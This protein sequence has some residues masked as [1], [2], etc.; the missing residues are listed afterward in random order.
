METEKVLW[1]VNYDELKWFVGRAKYVKATAVAIRTDNDLLKA[2]PA[3]KDEGIKVYGW[4]WPSAKRDAAMKEAAKVADLLAKGLDG[5]FVD[6]E[7]DT[8]KPWDWN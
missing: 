2:I 7:G 1:V 8:G 3:F 5:Y 4:R 6:P